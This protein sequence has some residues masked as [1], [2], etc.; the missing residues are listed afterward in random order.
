V[1]RI[2]EREAG[3]TLPRLFI[4]NVAR[5]VRRLYGIM[6]EVEIDNIVAARDVD[7]YHVKRVAFQRWRVYKLT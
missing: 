3:Y 6:R 1:A 4:E 2:E 7:L 5:F